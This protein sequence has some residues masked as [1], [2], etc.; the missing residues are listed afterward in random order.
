MQYSGGGGGEGSVFRRGGGAVL[1]GRGVFRGSA[2]FGGGGVQYSGG[3]A[4]RR[5]DRVGSLFQ[6]PSC[7]PSASNSFKTFLEFGGV[8]FTHSL[9]SAVRNMAATTV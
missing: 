4:F 9:L 8:N 3:A 2:V 7:V 6:N 1:G 5:G